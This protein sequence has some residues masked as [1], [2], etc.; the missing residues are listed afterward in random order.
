MQKLTL[1][2]A[3]FLVSYLALATGTQAASEQDS[4]THL[5][6]D[7]LV[8]ALVDPNAET[9]EFS[10][11]RG[12][13]PSNAA[14]YE[15]VYLNSASKVVP[16]NKHE[17]D[18]SLYYSVDATYPQIAGKSMSDAD[19]AFNKRINDIV[20][21]EMQQFKNSVKLDMPHMKSLPKEVRNNTFKIDYDID[22]IHELSLVSVRFTIQGMQAG[23]AHPFRSHRVVNFDLAHNK[24][25]A[26]SDL[27]KSDTKYLDALAKYSRSKLEK[28]VNIKDKWMIDEGAKA[29]AKNYKNWNIEKGAIL[30]TFDE[31]QVAPYYYGPQEI[32]IPY[33]DLQHMLSPQAKIISSIK[34]NTA[35]IG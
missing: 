17:K 2:A 18:R 10:A 30:I 4:S 21:E 7:T 22:V 29:I 27:F 12:T 32:E 35:H 25:L 20:V 14:E 11:T 16:K 33:S 15:A 24:E 9:V 31:Y 13:T 8:S 19:S 3:T 23:R 26:L 28:T 34:D 1:L 6:G 5:T